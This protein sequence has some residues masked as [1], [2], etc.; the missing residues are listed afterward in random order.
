MPISLKPPDVIDKAT[1]RDCH[2]CECSGRLELP[3]L[4]M[5]HFDRSM[6]FQVRVEKQEG[7]DSKSHLVANKKDLT[8]FKDDQA[9]FC[10]QMFR[11]T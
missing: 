7:K 4:A 6:Q 10:E 9:L 8:Q 2:Q 3:W 1:E 11:A 5:Y